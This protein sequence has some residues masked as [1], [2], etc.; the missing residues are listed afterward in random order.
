MPWTNQD[1]LPCWPKP[2][3][4]GY[5]TVQKNSDATA[6]GYERNVNDHVLFLVDSSSRDNSPS[7]ERGSHSFELPFGKNSI[8]YKGLLGISRFLGQKSL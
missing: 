5:L 4:H 1:I 6:Q 2:R 7:S 8:A 3:T